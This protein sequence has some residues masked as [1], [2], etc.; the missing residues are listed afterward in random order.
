MK[1][2][3]Q[4]LRREQKA[5]QAKQDKINEALAKKPSVGYLNKFGM[6]SEQIKR[7]NSK[8]E[9]QNP[10]QVVNGRCRNRKK[11]RVT[12]PTKASKRVRLHMPNAR[13]L[14]D[15]NPVAQNMPVP[16]W[17]TS[18]K[19][20]VDV[21]IIVP[22]YRSQEVIKQQIL[23][24]DL[25]NDGLTKEIIYCDDCC[26]GRSHAA[27]IST[28]TKR[29]RELKNPVGRIIINQNH[30]GFSPTC[31]IGAGD[32]RGDYLIF[33]NADCVV[34]QGW[35]K[36]LIDRLKSDPEIGIVGNL[37]LSQDGTIDSAG[38]EWSWTSKTFQHI[39]KTIYKGKRLNNPFAIAKAPKD[40]LLPGEREMVTGCCMAVPKKLFEDIGGFDEHYRIGYWEDAD[41][42]LAVRSAGYKVYYEPKSKI[43][44]HGGHSRSANHQFSQHNK[45]LFKNRWLDTGRID[46]HIKI[47]RPNAVNKTIKD[48][49]SGKVVGCVI[50]CN[51]EEFLEASV[52]SASPLVDKWVF[53]IGGNEY[54]YKA[55][56]CNKDGR[57]NDNTLEIA[58]ELA[59]EYNGVV[60]EPKRL[61]K[62][63][64]EMRNAY[65][66]HLKKGDWMFMVDGDE[67]YKE[68][69]LWRITELM[70]DYNVLIMQFWLFWNNINTLGKGAWEKYPQE[71]MVKW[72]EGYKYRGRNHL[73]VSN[74]RNELVHTLG[75]TWSGS[76]KLFYHYSWVRPIEKIRQKLFYYKFQSGNNND[77]YVDNVF[78]KWRTDPKSVKATHP[79]GRGSATKF[80][81]CHPPEIRQLIKSGKLDF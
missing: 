18:R 42:N 73:F 5:R 52:K 1:K 50:A 8:T 23:S 63:K 75:N 12:R 72:G 66:P 70:K 37:Q 13:E 22:M 29:Q 74:G 46:K 32:A 27:V 20:K 10:K 7:A 58:H 25:K 17:F 60:I 43:V 34:T 59:A 31:N 41:F 2:I 57:P 30:S 21:S 16:S 9:S 14:T 54:A 51:E 44:H 39:G 19:R 24:W 53:V 40:L 65:V 61:W 56:M 3:N 76:E 6:T 36:P 35:I 48:N 80:N 79:M 78:L 68:S 55:G 62:D 49:K 47:K 71:R 38:S 15:I 81:G 69:Q 45:L 77:A 28:W 4:S 11:G 33:L 64:V 67:V 26:P